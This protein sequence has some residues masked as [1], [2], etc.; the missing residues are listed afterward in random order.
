LTLLLLV[1]LK[2]YDRCADCL[3]TYRFTGE[4]RCCS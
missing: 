3:F 1:T 2:R 4:I